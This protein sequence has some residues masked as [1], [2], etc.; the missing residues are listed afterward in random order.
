LGP[1]LERQET[2]YSLQ[3]AGGLLSSSSPT[4]SG[5]IRTVAQVPELGHDDNDD[6]HDDLTNTRPND[7]IRLQDLGSFLAFNRRTDLDN[8]GS[9]RTNAWSP[10]AGRAAPSN[11]A[12]LPPRGQSG[13]ESMNFQ[14]PGG[15]LER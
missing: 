3:D 5:D 13:Y 1:M 10:Q 14:D 8:L 2:Q 7:S 9:R 6:N 4:S 11:S 12:H 15:L